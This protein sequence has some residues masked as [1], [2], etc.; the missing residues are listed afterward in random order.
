MQTPNDDAERI[1]DNIKAIL[2]WA[3]MCLGFT[4]SVAIVVKLLFPNQQPPTTTINNYF[5]N[6]K[7]IM[8]G[9]PKFPNGY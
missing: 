8:Y 9:V 2:V 6:N 5:V 7:E 4:L 1:L 3:L